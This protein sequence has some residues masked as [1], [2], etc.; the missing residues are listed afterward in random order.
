MPNQ[1]I[2]LFVY[3]QLG[4]DTLKHL[5]EKGFNITAVFTH[6]DS[7][8]E[9]IWFPSVKEYAAKNNIK[10]FTPEKSELSN[11]AEK[12]KELSP[13]IILSVYYRFLIPVNILHVPRHGA[14]N[15][16]GSLLPQFRGKA[17]VNWALLKGAKETG[18]TLH[19]MVEKPDAGAIVSQKKCAIDLFDTAGIVTEKLRPLLI[20]ILSENMEK[21]VSGKSEKHFMDIN[22]GSYFSGRTAKDGEI[23][24]DKMDDFEAHN[25]V[26]AVQPSPQFP[27]S[28][29]TDKSGEKFIEIY[30]TT[31]LEEP[32]NKRGLSQSKQ[33]FFLY[34]DKENQFW[35][36]CT[37]DSWLKVLKYNIT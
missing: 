29:L 5:Y 28:F 30:Q 35:I 6:E 37:N 18:L 9:H 4:F 10:V 34:R 25:L 27:A 19:E 13:N 23:F 33:N 16:H 8:H 21:L 11:Y 22:K 15:I 24:P 1:K 20:E 17:P 7:A 2:I 12:I 14:F 31:P 26:R 32:K 36:K 3:S